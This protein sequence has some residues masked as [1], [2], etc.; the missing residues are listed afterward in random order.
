[1]SI[2]PLDSIAPV[3]SVEPLPGYDPTIGRWLWVLEDTRRE[4]K[5]ALTGLAPATLDWTPHQS[6]NSIGTL[7]YH[8]ALI[9]LDWLYREVLEDQPYPEEVKALFAVPHRGAQGLL[10]PVQ[11][12]TLE[13]H[14]HRLD[15][16]RMYLLT[17]FRGMT[18]LEFRRLRPFP[19]YRVSP[20]WVLHHLIQHEAEHRGHIQLL[21]GSAERELD[22]H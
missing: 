19:E 12:D 3:R 16:V 21:R 7:L 18:I 17:S 15:L 20:E 8:V 1:L 2:E 11:G 6:E 13:H 5:E 14:L 4:T 22:S 9:E 10:S